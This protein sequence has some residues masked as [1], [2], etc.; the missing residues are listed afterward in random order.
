MRQP[1][2]SICYIGGP[3]HGRERPI[4][5]SPRG[6]AARV[7]MPVDH[8][9]RQELAVYRLRNQNGDWSYCHEHTAS[10]EELGVDASRS[11]RQ[12]QEEWTPV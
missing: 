11:E 7:A 2:F 10:V 5:G 6:L 9:A 8:S 4:Q 1:H 3:W 12:R